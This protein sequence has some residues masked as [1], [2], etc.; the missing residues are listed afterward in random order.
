MIMQ[1]DMRNVHM[2]FEMTICPCN[3]L[4]NTGVLRTMCGALDQASDKKINLQ[5]FFI[6]ESS[7]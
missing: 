2:W 7:K 3:I 5:Q 6:I 4:T 1:I